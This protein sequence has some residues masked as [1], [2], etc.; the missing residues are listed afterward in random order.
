MDTRTTT[1]AIFKKFHIHRGDNRPFTGVISS[2]RTKLAELFGELGF[3]KGAEIGVRAGE[4]AAVLLSKNPNLHLILIDPW[5]PFHQCTQE[6]QD[7]YYK[8][9]MQILEPYAN[10]IEIKKMTSLEA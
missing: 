6:K 1:K 2:D 8:R 4:N 7:L 9:C 3:T 10:R 5:T